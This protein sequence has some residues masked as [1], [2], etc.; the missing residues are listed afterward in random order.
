[1]FS[2]NL[3]L[4]RGSFPYPGEGCAERQREG[5]V[6]KP[7]SCRELT[8]TK[9]HLQP[10]YQVDAAEGMLWCSGLSPCVPVEGGRESKELLCSHRLRG[11]TWAARE[12]SK[13]RAGFQQSLLGQPPAQ[14]PH[15]D[16]NVLLE[17]ERA[18]GYTPVA[19][20]SQSSCHWLA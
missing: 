1:M 5:Q 19:R 9:C 16:S 12:P 7:A 20:C 10:D 2:Q 3:L 15:Q 14:L 17:C 6:S 18:E 13:N 11:R 4:Q 8:V